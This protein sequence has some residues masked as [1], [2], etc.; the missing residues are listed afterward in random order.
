[1]S[2]WLI[3][4]PNQG[5]TEKAILS[6]L[7]AATKGLSKNLPF[8]V[9]QLK[10][11]TLDSLM[12]LSDDLAK[13]DAVV[14][15]VAKKIEKTWVDLQKTDSEDKKDAAAAEGGRAPSKKKEESKQAEQ[16]Q[17]KIGSGTARDFVEKFSWN[18]TRYP[19]RSP[20][21]TLSEL[22]VKESAKAD[23]AI[24][25][26]LA[27]YNEVR[28]SYAA[29]DRKDTG[30]LLVK[31]LGGLVKEKDLIEKGHLTTLLV[32]V[33]RLRTVE[34]ETQ[35]ET[36]EEAQRQK[37]EAERERKERE[38]KAKQEE[39]MQREKEREEHRAKKAH[40]HEEEEE[41]DSE[42]REELKRK[43]EEEKTQQEAEKKS[44]ED[45][46]AAKNKRLPC[47]VVVPRSAKRIVDDEK[48][49]FVL[50]R[51]VVLKDGAEY[52]KNIC[53]EKRPER[54]GEG[55]R[56]RRWRLCAAADCLR[57]LLCCHCCQVHRAAV[58]ARPC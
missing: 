17:L 28:S 37:D 39:Q 21:R 13:Q 9:P 8:R 14:G 15:Q 26:Q 31:G 34:F 10:V 38:A 53:R 2:Y 50:Y 51:V 42:E 3:S 30:S 24:K 20:L 19:K 16:E 58:Q 4:V 32:A 45:R 41:K 48:D 25:K 27:D 40:D 22:I 35:Y 12:S 46:E 56:R 36:M 11:G 44:R 47:P 57:C 29:I 7:D 18:E 6:E 43:A 5:R 54:A 52:I 23:E 55:E 1:M 33:P 49:E